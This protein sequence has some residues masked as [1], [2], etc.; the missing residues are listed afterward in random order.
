MAAAT[1]AVAAAALVHIIMQSS[2]MPIDAEHAAHQKSPRNR[3]SR[4]RAAVAIAG[5]A[6][7][8]RHRR[9]NRCRSCISIRL[10]RVVLVCCAG[11]GLQG[12]HLR[13]HSHSHS[14]S[15]DFKVDA[16]QQ[17]VIGCTLKHGKFWTS[18][19]PGSLGFVSIRHR[20]CGNRACAVA[21]PRGQV[22]RPWRCAAACKNAIS[23]RARGARR[24]QTH[25][26][27]VTCPEV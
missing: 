22:L 20:S 11:K 17:G 3:G 24:G 10:A 8:R 6:N 15:S 16:V 26:P 14:S 19:H 13:P 9:C 4:A 5:A 23:R 27:W 7:Q 21:R 1:A 25:Q 12:S 18:N 2:S